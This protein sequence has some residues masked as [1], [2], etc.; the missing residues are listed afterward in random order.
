[1]VQV[2]L[3]KIGIK[4]TF[5][6]NCMFLLEYLYLSCHVNDTD[7]CPLKN[8]NPFRNKAKKILNIM[9]LLWVTY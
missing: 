3:L 5:C 9:I 7:F 2:V 4:I 6:C 1:M 8:L